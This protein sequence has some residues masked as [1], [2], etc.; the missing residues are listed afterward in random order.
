MLNN[1]AAWIGK[2][3]LALPTERVSPCLNL[4]SSTASFR[5]IRQPY[6]EDK[7]V[8][9]NEARGVKFIHADLKA[10]PGVEI[11]GDVFDP[12][13]RTRLQELAVGSLLCCNVFEHVLKCE[14][15]ADICAQIVRLYGY[16][17]VGVPNSF[18]YHLDP[19]RHL[20]SPHA[21]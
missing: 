11:I 6:I 9:P 21:S 20:F 8:Q 3:L 16:I 7:I 15:L 12:T 19:D 4:G 10:A 17:I 2:A 14:A 1:E 18:P 13:F 5:K